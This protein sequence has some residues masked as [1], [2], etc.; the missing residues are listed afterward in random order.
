MIF[1][2]LGLQTP[3]IARE[4]PAACVRPWRVVH[5]HP[6]DATHFT[7]GLLLTEGRMFESVGLYGRSSIHELAW[8]GLRVLRSYALPDAAFGEGLAR[9]GNRLVQL[10]WREQI[11]LVFDLDLK[12]LGT[13]V[14][15]G[16]G[17]GLTTW[18][19][20]TGERLILS[21]GSAWLRVLNAETLVETNRIEVRDRGRPLPL[22]NELEFV[23]GEVL[24]NVWH[25]DRVVA[26]DPAD[27]KVRSSF[28]FSALR[29]RLSWPPGQQPVETD[30][31]GLAYDE[32]SGRLLVTG[33]LWPKLFEVETGDCGKVFSVR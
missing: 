2:V 5:E 23:R 24:A 14:Y 22:L 31:N 4:T 13:R 32:R 30:L 15:Q 8:P 11:A 20:D 26:I 33:K 25:S 1:F 21:D 18:R 29:K 3:S 16:E 17:W 27:G 12:L 6:H 28:D 7:Q 10:T 19:D 9:T